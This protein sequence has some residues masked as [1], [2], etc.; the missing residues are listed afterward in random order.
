MAIKIKRI[1]EEQRERV[2]YT[3]FWDR[4]GICDTSISS[5][6]NVIRLP[7]KSFGDDFSSNN[8]E[9]EFSRVSGLSDCGIFNNKTENIASLGNKDELVKCMSLVINTLCSEREN[10]AN[11]PFESPFGLNVTLYPFDFKNFNRSFFTFSSRR[12]LS[13]FL[14]DNSDI[15][16]ASSNY[17]SIM[18]GC[19]DV[20][21]RSSRDLF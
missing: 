7:L 17:S 13:S 14:R 16:F 10:F 2:V 11:S 9:N 15:I 5:L 12:N 4:F 20:F 3:G 21:S 8:L 6:N 1:V 19:F 18:E